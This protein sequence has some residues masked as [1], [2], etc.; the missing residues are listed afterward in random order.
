MTESQRDQLVTVLRTEDM[1]ERYHYTVEMK[2]NDELFKGGLA[3]RWD[4]YLV[5]VAAV[6]GGL[7]QILEAANS[8]E[9][10]VSVFLSTHKGGSLVLC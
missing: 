2:D 6:M 9:G 8:V 10:H 1:R 7:T 3:T 5:P 4:I